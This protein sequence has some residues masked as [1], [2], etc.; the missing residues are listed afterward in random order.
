VWAECL[1][2][3]DFAESDIAE[4]CSLFDVVYP[5]DG[6][7]VEQTLALAQL[8]DAL[9]RAHEKTGL[10]IAPHRVQGHGSYA[11]ALFVSRGM[12]RAPAM[13]RSDAN[14]A[15]RAS[16]G[17]ES[18]PYVCKY[19]VPVAPLDFGGCY[20]AV[21]ALSNAW[22]MYRAERIAVEGMA[23][24]EATAAAEKV[25]A[26]YREWLLFNG[27]APSRDDWHFLLTTVFEID[28]HGDVLPHHPHDKKDNTMRVGSV[29]ASSDPLLRMGGD[30]VRSI[31]QT[32]K[33]PHILQAYRC[34]PVGDRAL[35]TPDPFVELWSLRQ[36]LEGD[37]SISANERERWDGWAKSVGNALASGIPIEAHDRPAHKRE[38]VLVGDDDKPVRRQ[39][40]EERGPFYCPIIASGIQ[41]GARLLLYLP[42]ALVEQRSGTIVYTDTDAAR[43]I[44]CQEEN[45]TVF[46]PKLGMRK[47]LSYREVNEIRWKIDELLSELVPNLP[48]G[49]RRVMTTVV[50]T[51]LPGRMEAS[52]LTTSPELPER[53]E[54]PWTDVFEPCLPACVPEPRLLK[55]EPVCEPRASGFRRSDLYHFVIT[56]KRCS[57]LRIRYRAPHVENRFRANG[58]P[59]PVLVGDYVSD[60]IEVVAYSKHGLVQHVEWDNYEKE[61]WEHILTSLSWDDIIGANA[62]KAKPLPFAEEPHLGLVRATRMVD[63]RAIPG[64]RPMARMVAATPW[65]FCGL[66][67][68]HLVAAYYAGFDSYSADWYD[69]K[70]RDPRALIPFEQWDFDADRLDVLP[71]EPMSRFVSRFARHAPK[72]AVTPDGEPCMGETVGAIYPA[73]IIVTGIV[74]VGK[75]TRHIA[76]QGTAGILPTQGKITYRQAHRIEDVLTFMQRRK[77]QVGAFQL[78]LEAAESDIAGRTLRR[79]L[80]SENGYRPND[81]TTAQRLTGLAERLAEEEGLSVEE[82]ILQKVTPRVCQGCGAPL[83]NGSRKWCSP[84]CRHKAYREGKKEI[85]R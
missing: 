35:E 28:P 66:P 17:G 73:P 15:L 37:A 30:V 34:V 48:P 61:M 45:R 50:H 5:T 84:A 32:G 38:R 47:A 18:F 36:R 1:S 33:T 44:A 70:T 79:A 46:V 24:E 53:W 55:L 19:P 12:D 76:D 31:L 71:V 77:R 9:L 59:Y 51:K 22:R 57:F 64:M 81:R 20:V 75:R 39:T 49:P 29:T 43:V 23:T 74:L 65:G 11:K 72:R 85:A 25:T 7:L 69:W 80:N 42:V 27:L 63:V 2:G 3:T 78:S 6:D 8:C 21:A 82:S 16:F 10:P 60:G 26:T 40:V 4:A 54:V 14:R 52:W 83:A 68:G 67:S 62:I 56:S 13:S 58:T 41:A